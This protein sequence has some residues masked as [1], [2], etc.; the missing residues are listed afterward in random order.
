MT[1][2]PYILE[3]ASCRAR[4]LV[5]IAGLKSEDWEATSQLQSLELPLGELPT[6][7]AGAKTGR[8]GSRVYQMTRQWR[9]AFLRAEFSARLPQEA[10]GEQ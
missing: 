4:L 8:S 10:G 6:L 9:D 1:I 3:Q 2:D 5:A 7:E